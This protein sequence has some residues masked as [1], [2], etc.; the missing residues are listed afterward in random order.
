M[1]NNKSATA[2]KFWLQSFFRG[3]RTHAQQTTRVESSA[4]LRLLIFLLAILI[5]AFA[6]PSPAFLMI[7]SACKL[8]KQGDNVQPCIHFPIWNQPVDPCPVL[9]GQTKSI[10]ILGLSNGPSN[11]GLYC[12]PC[13]SHE[14]GLQSL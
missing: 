8:N 13:G 4:Y 9:T 5:P 10:P 14:S 12:R 2:A 7:Y 11:Y 6:S 3:R 1:K